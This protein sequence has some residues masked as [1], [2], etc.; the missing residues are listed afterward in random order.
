MQMGLNAISQILL[1]EVCERVK[2]IGFLLVNY[3]RD[4]PERVI[5]FFF[6]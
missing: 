4:N 6:L 3:I 5:A 2:G 1:F